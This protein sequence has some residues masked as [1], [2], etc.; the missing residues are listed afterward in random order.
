MGGSCDNVASTKVVDKLGLPTISHTKPY[1]LQWLSEVGEIMVNKQ[2]LINFTIGKYKDEVL[3]DV[4]PMEATHLL[5]G[6]PWQYDR[7]VL[8]DGLSNTMSFSFKGRKVILKP[9][10][11]K[12]VHGTK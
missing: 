11:S 3:C 5:L 2:V 8:H 1:K 7:N 10:S 4:V 12:E 6:R 9:L